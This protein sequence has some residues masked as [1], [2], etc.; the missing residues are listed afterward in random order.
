MPDAQN[1]EPSKF[2]AEVV[3]KIQGWLHDYTALRT[4]DILKFQEDSGIRG[5]LFE[6]GV[7][8]GRYFSILLASG[9]RSESGVFGLDTFQYVRQQAVEDEL[10]GFFGSGLSRAKLIQGMSSD[11]EPAMLLHELGERPRFISIDGSHEKADVYR[12]LVLC[13]DI[14]ANEGI[15]A[16]DDFLNPGAI[17][18]NEATNLYLSVPRRVVPFAYIPNKLLLCRP[19]QSERFRSMLDRYVLADTVSAISANYRN[20]PSILPFCGSPMLVA[21]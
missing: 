4:I 10:R 21:T 19:A 6:I 16:V 9:I 14:L 1:L 11:F 12:D 20:K 17:G 18:V 7:F 2:L 13:D 8:K 15:I 5:P 3:N